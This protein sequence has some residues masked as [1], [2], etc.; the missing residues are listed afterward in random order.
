MLDLATNRRLTKAFIDFNPVTITLIPR[1]KVKKPAGGFAWEE[2]AP[3]DPQVFTITEQSTVGG[4][5]RPSLTSDGIE[6]EVEFI[7]IAEHTAQVARSDVFVHQGRDWEVVDL[8]IDNG[9]EIRALVAA[10]G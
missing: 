3:R 5:P 1:A 2:Q 6:R 10:R 4:Q 7:L 8:Y 9:Y